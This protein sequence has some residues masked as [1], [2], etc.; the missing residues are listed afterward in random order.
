MEPQSSIV[1]L[2]PRID[3][4]WSAFVCRHP[5]SSIFHQGPWLEALHQTYGY[6]SVVYCKTRE[7]EIVS[8]IVFCEIRS[9]LTGNRL[10]SL[11]FSDHCEPLVENAGEVNQLL[12]SASQE[13]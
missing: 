7:K 13:L 9:W 10:V 3:E 12:A 4:R 8:G 5:R 11:P 2:D 6:R 1:K